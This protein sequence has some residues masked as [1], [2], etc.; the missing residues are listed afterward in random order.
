MNNNDNYKY[1]KVGHAWADPW[2]DDQE[3][4]CEYRFRKPGRHEISR[5]N[6]EVSKSASVAQ[7]NLLVGIVHPEDLN[8]LKADLEQYPGLLMSLTAWVLKA[9]GFGDLGN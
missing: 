4:R 6:K 5:F 7:N 2:D 1:I 8:L 9:C 3:V